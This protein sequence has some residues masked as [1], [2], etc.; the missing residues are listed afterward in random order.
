VTD[1]EAWKAARKALNEI[2]AERGALTAPLREEFAAR[3]KELLDPTEERYRAAAEHF[4]QVQGKTGEPLGH[5]EGC[6]E[7]IFE[8]E[9]YHAGDDIFGLCAACAPTYEDVLA[10]PENFKGAD[11]E[12]MTAEEAKA[13]FDEHIGGGGAP[14]DKLVHP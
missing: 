10:N 9:P 5:C 2:E 13:I 4:D 6:D 1:K 14:T 12:P 7:P 11:D 8:G 3:I